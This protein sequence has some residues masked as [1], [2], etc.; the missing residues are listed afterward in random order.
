[1]STRL[2][3]RY[4]T[5]GTRLHLNDGPIDL[6]IAA[7]GT[8]CAVA[9]A[10]DAAIAC[11]ASILDELCTELNLLRAASTAEVTANGPVA[12]QMQRA[13]AP[14]ARSA[15]ITPMAAVAGAVAQHVLA[16][17][18]DAA[19]LDRAWVNNG[20]DIALHLAQGARLAIGMVDRPDRPS[21]FGAITIGSTDP[22]RGIATSGW[23]GR[24]FSLGIA[25]A[26][27]VLARDAAAADAAA[28]MIA[29]AIDL[30][31]HP[32]V[33]RAP[34]ATLDPQSDLGARLVTR[35]VGPLS[36]EDIAI[37]LDAGEIQAQALVE[38][39][40][41]AS[42]ALHLQ[43]VTRI[44]GQAIQQNIIREMSSCHQPPRMESPS[45]NS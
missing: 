44:I 12:R 20:G 16:A 38:T 24:S 11:A 29:N 19:V 7:F 8:S 17:M 21:L 27:T 35:T 40:L 34:A 5:G 3:V 22:V 32:S 31:G 14:F 13:V 37:A 30:P 39:G 9:T 42:A 41:I 33:S 23:R 25:D 15:F 26:V 1:M 45:A 28:T 18:Q 4:I 10:H 2:S 36:T 6:V 43:G